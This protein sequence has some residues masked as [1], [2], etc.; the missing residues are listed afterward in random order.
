MCTV[1][2]Y[3]SPGFWIVL[4]VV[5]QIVLWNFKLVNMVPVRFVL[6]NE[7]FVLVYSENSINR[8]KGVVPC[9]GMRA[10]IML[11]FRA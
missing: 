3:P 7:R 9:A 6:E 1:S 5:S 4:E 11:T 10:C 2:K 8:E